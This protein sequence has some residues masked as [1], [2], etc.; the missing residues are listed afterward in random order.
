MRI[1]RRSRHVS[2]RKLN[3][4]GFNDSDEDYIILNPG[5]ELLLSFKD[6][7][8]ISLIKQAWV[9]AEGYYVPLQQNVT[10]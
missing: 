2:L 1:P 8:K 4:D 9:V 6:Y 7:D 10:N 5:D 3:S